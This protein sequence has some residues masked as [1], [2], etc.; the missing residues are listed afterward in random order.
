MSKKNREQIAIRCVYPGCTHTSS[1]GGQC[2]KHYQ[3]THTRLKSGKVTR[4]ELEERGLLLKKGQAQGGS[5][6]SFTALEP[7]SEERG[8]P[9]VEVVTIPVEA[10]GLNQQQLAQLRSERAVLLRALENLVG[11][12]GVSA[13]LE[14]VEEQLDA[15][16]TGKIRDAMR[17]AEEAA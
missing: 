7:G 12:A 5:V 13:A 9:P 1:R 3:A 15:E 14:G 11:K 6:K 8:Q 2:H 16:A 10:W 4:A 17:A